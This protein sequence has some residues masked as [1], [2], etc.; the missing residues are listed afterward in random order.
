MREATVTDIEQRQ[1]TGHEQ[2]YD[3]DLSICRV[4]FGV[5]VASMQPQ[6]L[7]LNDGGHAEVD[8]NRMQGSGKKSPEIRQRPGS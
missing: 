4:S 5:V 3:A 6:V 2:L 8:K 1:V 7:V